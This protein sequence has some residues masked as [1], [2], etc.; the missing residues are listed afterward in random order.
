[1]NNIIIKIIASGLMSTLTT[2]MVATWF[3]IQELFGEQMAMYLLIPAY[4]WSLLTLWGDEIKETLR[5]GKLPIKQI[6]NVIEDVNERPV[7]TMVAFASKQL[8]KY[9]K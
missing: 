8:P 5:T 4:V 9:R 1:M 6:T 3:V 2:S 7:E